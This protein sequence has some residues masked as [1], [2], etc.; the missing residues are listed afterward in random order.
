MEGYDYV[1]NANNKEL[2]AEPTTIVRV[3]KGPVIDSESE[4]VGIT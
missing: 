3:M 4:N 2:T 1:S